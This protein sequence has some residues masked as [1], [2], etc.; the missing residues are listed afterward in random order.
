MVL[1]RESP[2]PVWGRG[3]EGAKVHV[4]LGRHEAAAT[5]IAGRWT[6]WLPPLPAGGP[7]TLEVRCGGEECIVGDVLLGDVYL[8]SGQSNIETSIGSLA[9]RD[10][11]AAQVRNDQVRLFLQKPRAAVQPAEDGGEGE[12][13]RGTPDRAAIL[14]ALPLLFGLRIQERLGL[15]VGLIVAAAGGSG[16][17]PWLPP[18]A[19]D[20]H[21]DLRAHW[22][23]YPWR[24]EKE[25]ALHEQWAT[26]RRARDEENTRRRSAGEELQP[27]TKYLFFGPRGPRCPAQP[28]GL[29]HGM[30][31]PL[32][33]FPLRGVIWYQGET[34][35]E[36]PAFYARNLRELI[37]GWRARWAHEALPFFVIQLAR[38]AVTETAPNWPFIREAQAQ[39]AASVRDVALVPG[40]DLGDPA[41]IH[42]ADKE[43]L[44]ERLARFAF[45]T[46]AP[47]PQAPRILG[48]R[49]LPGGEIELALS[50]P[51]RTIGSAI[52][53]FELAYE[54]GAF[55]EASAR[56]ITPRTL[57][58]RAPTGAM[59]G[60]PQ[61]R[62]L[63]EGAPTPLLFSEDG[64]PLLPYRTDGRPAPLVIE[65]HYQSA[66]PNG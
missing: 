58:L 16:I 32:A 36:L 9:A 60:M 8:C 28:A 66:W 22:T 41:D 18:A 65:T 24:L 57:R 12:W 35:A 3:P 64:L 43:V 62:Y 13:L 50:R 48:T 63:W 56:L 1:P 11:L 10:E 15:P 61:L 31:Q 14:P 7:C 5:V 47:A 37:G 17:T 40:V 42:P 19:F 44:A 45:A 4:R 29:F 30:I 6:A 33:P 34:D 38:C 2:L 51:V 39:V 20:R 27:W 46:S 26:A 55:Q 53:G 52:T 25:E 54:D 49:I 21:E 59:T 23:S